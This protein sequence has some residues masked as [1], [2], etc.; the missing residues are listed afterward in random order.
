MAKI[1]S[2]VRV[3][4]LDAVSDS[5][6]RHYKAADAL[7]GDPF[8]K[9]TFAELEDLSARITT[10]VK[11]DAVL[12]TL[13]DA[14]GVRDE[15][16]R[17]IGDML[18]GFV[19]FPIPAIKAAA[20]PL[21]AVF[22]KYGKGITSA[23]NTEESGLISSMLEDFA[24]SALAENVAALTGLSEAIDALQKAQTAFEKAADDYTAAK[25]GKGESASSLKK[26]ILD[27]ING[28]LVPY[29]DATAKSGLAGYAE[30]AAKVAEEVN[31]VNAMVAKRSK[32]SASG[33]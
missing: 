29:L 21:K 4:E 26:P 27:C 6:L 3:A 8:L 10:A 25:T 1:S 2:K 33:E 5:L 9:A 18:T 16:V 31:K 14:D 11:Q 12:S 7:A 24:A 22:D 17:A 28:K 23:N 32:A 15:A 13:D 30:F 19:A 20:L